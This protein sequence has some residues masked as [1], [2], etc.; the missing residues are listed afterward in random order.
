MLH[1]IGARRWIARI[2]ISWAIVSASTAFVTSPL[3]FYAIRFLLGVM[4]AGFFPGII[5]YLTYWY[6]SPRRG[7]ATAIVLSAIP[8]A[9]VLGGLISGWIMASM[10]GLRGWKGWQWLFWVE[11]VPSILLGFIVWHYLDDRV[12]H[13]RWLSEDQR[14]FVAREI[15]REATMK[16]DAK[17]LTVLT[18]PRVWFLAAVY[19]AYTGGINGIALWLPTII[20]TL[21]VKSVLHVGLLSAIPWSCGIIGMYLLARR[22]DRRLEFGWHSAAAALV[23][24]FGLI[25]SVE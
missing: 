19:F 12:E 11:A 6:P 5:Y 1:R 20:H 18:N 24:C 7:E 9:G 14:S 21:G 4:K 22:V 23:G 17:V 13:A 3:S 15:A 16:S 2:M 8:V 10:A 25:L